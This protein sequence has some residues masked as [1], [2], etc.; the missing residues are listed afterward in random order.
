[1]FYVHS[2]SC[3]AE[4]GTS[5]SATTCPRQ[6]TLPS[7]GAGEAPTGKLLRAGR[8]PNKGP[9]KPHP[10]PGAHAAGPGTALHF[11]PAAQQAAGHQNHAALCVMVSWSIASGGTVLLHNKLLDSRTMQLFVLWWVE[12][13]RAVVLFYYATSCWTPEPCSSLCHG[14]WEHCEQCFCPTSNVYVGSGL[15]CTVVAG[16]D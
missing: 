10:L 16:F 9:G 13:L 12:A 2:W 3:S 1:M 5:A 8:Q 6:R 7:A 11:L 14:E 15:A 4:V